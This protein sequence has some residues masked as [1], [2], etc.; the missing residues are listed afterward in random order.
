[1]SDENAD[2]DVTAKERVADKSPA[3]KGSSAKRADANNDKQMQALT[4][5]LAEVKSSLA[6]AEKAKSEIASKY[7]GIDPEKAKEAMEAM[8][9]AEKGALERKGEYDKA[10]KMQEESFTDLIAKKD[11][12]IDALEQK[13]STLESKMKTVSVERSFSNS[14]FINE[15]VALSPNRMMQLWGDHFEVTEDGSMRAYNEPVSSRTKILLLNDHGKPASFDEALEK[16]ISS[17]P[18]SSLFLKSKLKPGAKSSSEQASIKTQEKGDQ[19]SV[20]PGF[21][22]IRTAMSQ[23]MNK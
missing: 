20:S 9:K 3:K 14:S 18:D 5:Q 21:D 22:R 16:I 4:S 2:K 13:M 7:D 8:A 15:D 19:D 6:E 1:M 12:V 10:L 11:K 17:Q 23:F